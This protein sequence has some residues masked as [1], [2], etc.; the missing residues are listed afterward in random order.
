[1][2]DCNNLQIYRD[3]LDNKNTC[4]WLCQFYEALS[5]M[6]TFDNLRIHD[7]IDSVM[8]EN[9]NFMLKNLNLPTGKHIFLIQNPGI[10]PVPPTFKPSSI[11]EL[12]KKR[13]LRII[14]PSLC[15]QF[16][17]FSLCFFVCIPFFNRLP[18]HIEWKFIFHFLRFVCRYG[19]ES[20]VWVGKSWQNIKRSI[21]VQGWKQ[22]I[23]L[24]PSD[25]NGWFCSKNIFY[26]MKLFPLTD[27]FSRPSSKLHLPS[28]GF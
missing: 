10:Q 6:E 18:R 25:E 7:T 23:A 9:C 22:F 16:Y 3:E 13:S 21:L 11:Q 8:L 17:D 4:S 19:N 24:N 20:G 12:G 28:I 5:P 15:V 26:G 1:M 2:H 27:P 14:C